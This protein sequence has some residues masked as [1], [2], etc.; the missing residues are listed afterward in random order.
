[1]PKESGNRLYYGDNLPI[2]RAYIKDE[3]VDQG[4]AARTTVAFLEGD[5]GQHHAPG[6]N[7]ARSFSSG[8]GKAPFIPPMV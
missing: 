3:S 6:A 2:L 8:S 7:R 1:M 5:S 4:S